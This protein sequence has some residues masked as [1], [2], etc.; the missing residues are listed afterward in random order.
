MNEPQ[1]DAMSGQPS[2]LAVFAHPDDEAIAC[3]GLLAWCATLGVQVSLLCLT[4][5][6]HGSDNRKSNLQNAT[7]LGGV[8][9]RELREAA[10]ALGIDDVTLLRHE[11]GMLPWS[12]TE[13]L[14]TDISNTIARTA[15][16]VVLTFD[17]DGLY[18]HPDHIAA[19]ERTTAAVAALAGPPALYYVAIP[20]GAIRSVVA[21][22]NTVTANV[23]GGVF[24][25]TVLGVTDPD[26]FGTLAPR[27]TLVLD[28]AAFTD[29]KLQ[30][31]RCHRSQLGND[32]LT[33]LTA[34]SAS[35]LLATEHYRRAKV[36]RRGPTFLDRLAVDSNQSE[37]PT[38]SF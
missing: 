31:I 36:G 19:H 26:A 7:P 3:G 23:D 9:A 6:E 33:F 21:H 11:D 25:R 12:N 15:A 37:R 8:R 29:R 35:K 38:P 10:G 1:S 22:A 18:W 32:A 14:Q 34:E 30:A 24:P 4:H 2:L 5:G 28:V 13:Q 20:E 27:P 17:E 16:D